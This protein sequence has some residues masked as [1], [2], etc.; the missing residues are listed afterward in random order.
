MHAEAGEEFGERQGCIVELIK[1]LCGMSTRSRSFA[2][3][4]GDFIRA[5]GFIPT[6]EDPD[7]WIKKNPNHDGCH[8]ASTHV[9]DFLI[10]GTDLEPI[11]EGFKNNFEMRHEEVNPTSYLGL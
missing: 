5:L 3:Y 11:M 7:T 6:R 9:D 4:L 2:L 10:I 8:R 1:S